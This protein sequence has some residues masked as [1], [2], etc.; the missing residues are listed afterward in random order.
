M[1]AIPA[2]R[3]VVSADVGSDP[4][5]ALLLAAIGVLEHQAL[6]EE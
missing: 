1:T 5:T 3:T 2:I 6:K 4:R